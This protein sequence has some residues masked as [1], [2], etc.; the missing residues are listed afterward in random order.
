MASAEVD[1]TDEAQNDEYRAF[2]PRRSSCDGARD[3]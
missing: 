1:E 3:F 2:E